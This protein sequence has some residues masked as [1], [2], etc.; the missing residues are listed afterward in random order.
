MRVLVTG[1][2]G[3]AGRH[4]TAELKGAGHDPLLSDAQAGIPGIVPAD[5][6]DPKA[7]CAL[8]R[9]A[10]PDACVHLG[11]IA[12]VPAGWENPELVINVNLLGTVHLLEAFRLHASS[13]RLLIVSSSEVYG[14]MPAKTP[15]TEDAPFAPS[16]PYAVAK[17]GADLTALLYAK[18]YG[19]PVM[20][21]R[22]DNHTGPGQ[23][24]QFVAT[25]FA[26]QLLDI[27]TGKAPPQIKVGNLDSVRNFTDVRD[28]ARAYRLIIEKGQPGCAYNISSGTAAK[29]SSI[30]EI[31]IDI[32]GIRPEVVVDPARY[33]PA[34]ALPALDT[35]RLR[36][37]TGWAPKTPLHTTLTDIFTSLQTG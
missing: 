20:T 27:K 19:M 12:F 8:V 2:A 34:D 33:R 32:A 16:N 22:P 26:R 37:H 4:L 15:L 30:L 10:K 35:S 25:A 17:A 1:A 5:L 36:E 14:R 13:A 18:R 28:I 7:L 3:F 24:P 9:D 11:G 6:R 23:S 21:A 31:L 29:I